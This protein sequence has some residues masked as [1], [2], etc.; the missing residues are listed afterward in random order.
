MEL[1]KTF[2]QQGLRVFSFEDIEPL[3]KEKNF[4]KS[5]ARKILPVMGKNETLQRL[6]CGLYSLPTEFLS[7]GPIHSFE[8]AM[9]L[10]KKGAIS[11]RSAMGFYQLTDQM[12]HTVYVTVPRLKNANL[13]QKNNYLIDHT[14]FHIKR[15]N[16][17]LFFGAN[18]IFIGE[19]PIWITTMEK[20]LLDGLIDPAFC[21]GFL[22]VIHAFSNALPREVLDL[23][24]LWDY[25][26]KM[27]IVVRQRLGWMFETLNAYPAFQEKLMS[28]PIKS[29]QKLNPDGPRCGSIH[30]KWK[31]MENVK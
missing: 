16:P 23:D 11:H 6:G 30:K 29:I 3:L 22:E 1:I 18:R 25:T 13:S 27:P 19:A 8:I 10:A 26:K 17:D 7:G 9:K 5:Y 2:A 20:T 24:L 31:L 4:S 12:S 28:L 14:S 15:V 21:G